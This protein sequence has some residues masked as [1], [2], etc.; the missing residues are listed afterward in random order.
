LI[1]N[2]EMFEDE[3]L[4]Q[5]VQ[6]RLRAIEGVE[7]VQKWKGVGEGEGQEGKNVTMR[8]SIEYL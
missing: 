1:I 5:L 2:L 8:A 6:C 4:D 3:I 7:K